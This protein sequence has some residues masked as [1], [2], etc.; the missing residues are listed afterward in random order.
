[1]PPG[2]A[3]GFFAFDT[4]AI[5]QYEMTAPFIPEKESSLNWN[6]QRVGIKWP[7]GVG[8]QVI[9]S[10]KDRNAPGLSEIESW[11]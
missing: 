9:M 2:F 3:N 11:R 5:V 1:M 4:G 10:P 6:D 7:M 8:G